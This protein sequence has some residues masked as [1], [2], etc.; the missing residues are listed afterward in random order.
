MSPEPTATQRES[1]GQEIPFRP[2]LTGI[3]SSSVELSST[4]AGGNPPQGPVRG[5]AGPGEAARLART[6]IAHPEAMSVDFFN[7]LV[8]PSVN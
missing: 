3:R 5:V 6:A 7:R 4:N 8:M 1:V 2:S